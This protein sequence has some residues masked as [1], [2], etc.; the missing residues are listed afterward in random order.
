M[1]TQIFLQ[2]ERKITGISVTRVRAVIGPLGLAVP[3]ESLATGAVFADSFVHEGVQFVSYAGVESIEV[4]MQVLMEVR[5]RL[6]AVL[7]DMEVTRPTAA[8]S[9]L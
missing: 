9:A 1:T 4:H 5:M 8:G 6:V 2:E 3:Q 7:V